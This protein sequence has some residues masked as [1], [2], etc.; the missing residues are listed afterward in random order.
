M[1]AP[2]FTRFIARTI[3]N[4]I[5]SGLFFMPFILLQDKSPNETFLSISAIVGMIYFFLCDSLPN[6][7]S[8]G[9]KVCGLAVISRKTNK[10]CSVLQS[11]L[12]NLPLLL[13]LF[14]G[15][16]IIEG[17]FVVH[18]RRL[19]IGDRIAKTMVILN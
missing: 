1:Q 18:E 13:L 7:Q 6:G 9:K 19:R 16:G 8:L 15:L 11:F 3:D 10:S 14:L 4:F 17:F 2:R 12:R 5:S